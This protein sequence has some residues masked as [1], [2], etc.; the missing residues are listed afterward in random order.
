MMALFSDADVWDAD[1]RDYGFYG[2]ASISYNTCPTT[3]PSAIRFSLSSTFFNDF[4][5]WIWPNNALILG[6]PPE[7]GGADICG[8][9]GGGGGTPPVGK[10][11]ID[12]GG[13]GGGGGGGGIEDGGGGGG[14]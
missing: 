12:E 13:G 8:G 5:P 7:A 2:C 4:P 3:A 9:G 1:I 14:G 6:A 11:G 10:G